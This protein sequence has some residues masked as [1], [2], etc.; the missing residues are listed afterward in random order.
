[1]F[2]TAVM[3]VA[4]VQWSSSITNYSAEFTP[5]MCAPTCRSAHNGGRFRAAQVSKGIENN[6]PQAGEP[7]TN[8]F[9]QETAGIYTM[10]TSVSMAASN[11]VFVN[12]RT[13]TLAVTPGPANALASSLRYNGTDCAT[14]V[15]SA[16]SSV[17]SRA[18]SVRSR[19]SSVKSGAS[20]VRSGGERRLPPAPS[21]ENPTRKLQAPSPPPH[22]RSQSSAPAPP[23]SCLLPGGDSLL[24]KQNR[25]VVVLRR[26]DVVTW[27]AVQVCAIVTAGDDAYFTI[28]TRDEFGNLRTSGDTVI[29]SEYRLS[30]DPLTSL[31]EPT[32]PS[33]RQIVV[34][35]VRRS[36]VA[37]ARRS[38][39]SRFEA[40]PPAFQ[41][42]ASVERRLIV[43]GTY[44]VPLEL[45]EANEG[46]RL[47]VWVGSAAAT[48]IPIIGGTL[49]TV[50]AAVVFPR[51]T[52]VRSVDADSACSEVAVCR[53]A[54][55]GEPR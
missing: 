51:R 16:A 45:R 44:T 53:C 17:R 9:S 25:G 35:S 13:F 10:R 12:F 52:Y 34:P 41:R 32:L 40:W 43:R 48:R 54:L 26:S 28:V 6:V 46:W 27:G 39:D 22:R 14:S 24:M 7:I 5:G 38:V 31:V 42:V 4:A 3:F 19:A 33:G 1:M 8:T 23:G 11:G 37:S 49:V 47:G 30:T 20:S 21:S 18:F 15:V 29:S 2:V 50:Q 36:V 55:V